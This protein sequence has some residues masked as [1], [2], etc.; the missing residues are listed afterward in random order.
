ML[1]TTSGRVTIVFVSL[2]LL[3]VLIWQIVSSVTAADPL[4]EKEA[5]EH[6]EIQYKG[7]VVEK[8]LDG[9]DSILTLETETGR[10]EIVFDL[11]RAEVKNVQ[12]IQVNEKEGQSSK[13]EEIKKIANERYNG[14]ITSFTSQENDEAISYEVIIEEKEISYFI[15]LDEEGNILSTEEKLK[16]TQGP[17]TRIS[18][19][20]ASEIAAEEVEGTVDDVDFEEA[21]DGKP[22]Y[23]L[24]EVE[25]GDDLEAEVQ[26]H[27][28]SGEVLSVSWE[29]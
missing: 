14:E 27:A 7:N 1:R 22:P 18:K 4:S 25:R 9:D 17:N 21:V 8:Q 6:V 12:Q 23:F 16:V 26:V 28:I 19:E 5:I 15:T 2:L 3:T 24:I 11:E 29:D 20:E 13:E 10:Y